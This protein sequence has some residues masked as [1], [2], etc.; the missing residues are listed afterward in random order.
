[1]KNLFNNLELLSLLIISFILV[2]FMCD[3]G[4][5]IVRRN[6]MLVTL[7]VKRVKSKVRVALKIV[8]NCLH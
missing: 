2:T 7:R 4:G 8:V 5:D 6:Y 1:M 3:F